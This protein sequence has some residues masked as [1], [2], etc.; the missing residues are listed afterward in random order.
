RAMVG[1]E[2][3]FFADCRRYG[4][5][6]SFYLGPVPCYV[7]Y[8]PAVI[9]E[10]LLT[11]A[12]LFIKDASTRILSEVLGNGLLVSEGDF[13]RRQRKLAAP[14]LRRRQIANYA[15]QMVAFAVSHREC[16]E[17]EAPVDLHHAMMQ[18]TLEIV[19][20]TLFDLDFGGDG[21]RVTQAIGTAIEQL[22]SS[23]R[24]YLRSML[25][26]V[27]PMSQPF[28]AARAQ[29]R[30]SVDEL[31]ARRRDNLGDDLL[32]RLIAARDENGQPMAIEQVR[33]EAVT[34]FSA[35]HETT[36][37]ALTFA[38]VLLAQHPQVLAQMCEELD[39]VLGENPP[40]FDTLGQLEFTEAVVLETL[41]LYPPAWAIGREPIE[42]CELAG[43]RIPKGAQLYFS[44][45]HTQR[46]PRWFP[47]PERFNPARWLGGLEQRLPRFAY[48]PFGGG[49]RVCI[50]NHFAR[51]E[52][53]LVLATLAQKLT[54]K[55]INIENLE[56]RGRV[57]LRP[58]GPV[59][60]TIHH[61]TRP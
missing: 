26:G 21:Q 28:Q 10:V 31:I 42:D 9:E 52:T 59:M 43:Y 41:R 60:A 7:F 3:G 25:G 54:Y 6:V 19:V 18:L 34:M 11:R 58:S 53:I 45:M 51:M 37:L 57:T 22:Q 38:W 8:D 14:P 39:R 24:A 61:R 2:L 16:A 56:L 35:G 15:E 27:I 46:D 12:D 48:F 32:S 20:K 40:G 5:V 47:E 17:H 33:D 13:W 30:Q 36:A 1:N 44:Q 49:A 55:P 50:G 23:N 4:D 29:L